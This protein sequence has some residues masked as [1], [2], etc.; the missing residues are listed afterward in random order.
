MSTSDSD[1]DD[2]IRSDVEEELKQIS[3]KA[4]PKPKKKSKKSK[5]KSKKSKKSKNDAIKSDSDAEDS[6]NEPSDNE[7]SEEVSKA[8]NKRINELTDDTSSDTS[9]DDVE[10]MITKLEKRIS[11]LEEHM[12]SM[13][14]AFSVAAG[15]NPQ[16]NTKKK[17]KDPSYD[18]SKMQR[19]GIN[20]RLVFDE[21][22]WGKFDKPEDKSERMRTQ[23]IKPKYP[24]DIKNDKLREFILDRVNEDDAFEDDSWDKQK[25]D[26]WEIDKM[27]Q[28]NHVTNFIVIE[29][30]KLGFFT[31]EDEL[32]EKGNTV[33]KKYYDLTQGLFEGMFEE[34]ASSD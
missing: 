33:E 16:K 21:K 20:D 2:T 4:T 11:E 28:V 5:K 3:V 17:I 24:K 26:C 14:N 29:C 34:Y 22:N 7:P 9:S 27:L 30:E 8:R 15:G 13:K 32:S 18:L 19:N 31:E 25:L 6:D 10:T 12:N 23:R 1:I